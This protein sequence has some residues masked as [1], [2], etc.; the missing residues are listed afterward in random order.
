MLSRLRANP[1]LRAALLVL[2]LAFCGLGLAADWHQVHAA[3]LRLNW[4]DV[5]GAFLA[6]AI[7][8]GCMMLAW[9]AIVTDLG[10]PL[11]VP[12]TVRVM[13]ISQ[14]G[15][16]LPGAIWAFAAQVELGHDY[17]VPRRRGAAAVVI[18]LA[19]ALGTGLAIGVAALPI[20]SAGAVHHYWWM[21]ALAPLIALCLLPPVLRWLLDR[22][23]R[24]ARQQPLEQPLSS[25]GL[26]VAVA[27][28]VAGW[29]LWGLQAWLLISDVT[30]RTWGVVLV[31]LGAYALA[32]SAGILLVVFPGGIG[33][34]E[35]A[36]VVALA[37]VMPRG[38]A[39]LVAL[40]SR[41]VTTISD[42]AWAGVG[43]LIGR[44]A[45]RMTEQPLPGLEP[46]MTAPSPASP[47][48]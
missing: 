44:Q 5:G 7:G 6:A 32:W 23:F 48:A 35:L 42:V 28:T 41:V 4:Y 11:T 13:S 18:S 34:R 27:W 24:L 31:S 40:A 9:R 21:L 26:R 17:Q 29:L 45:K 1:L 38:S 37:P 30:G 46:T 22:A 36:L 12:A 39:I 25:R 10:S 19:V 14:I 16:Y 43:L 47:Q 15:K 8:S 3:L 33:P 20:A 2:A